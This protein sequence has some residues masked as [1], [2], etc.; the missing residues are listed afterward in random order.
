M[1]RTVQPALRSV[2][3]EG[4]SF[5]SRSWNNAS[6]LYILQKFAVSQRR[7]SALGPNFCGAE[8][9][10]VQVR[11]EITRQLY[12]TSRFSPARCSSLRC[13]GE[14]KRRALA[15]AANVNQF[16]GSARKW[17][18]DWRHPFSRN[19]NERT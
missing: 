5:A 19:F 11:I 10:L 15:H 18:G 17:P 14:G 12:L 3:L 2:V 7:S 1:T 16:L 9:D 4:Y 8:G 6:Q 13:I